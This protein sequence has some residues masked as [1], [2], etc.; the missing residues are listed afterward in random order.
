MTIATELQD[1]AYEILTEFGVAARVTTGDGQNVTG[2][3]VL[4]NRNAEDSNE[5][6][7]VQK[8]NTAYFTSPKVTITPGDVF[9]LGKV[10][11][12]IMSVEQFNPDALTNIVWKMEVST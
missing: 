10:R 8:T 1:V 12:L 4:L 11:Y 3:G 9:M 6:H 5:T 2:L 7:V